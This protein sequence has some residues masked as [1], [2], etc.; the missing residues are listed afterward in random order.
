M[1]LPD[2]K[3][4]F[5]LIKSETNESGEHFDTDIKYASKDICVPLSSFDHASLTITKTKEEVN[6]DDCSLLMRIEKE[7]EPDNI[8]T[9]QTA[10]SDEPHMDDLPNNTLSFINTCITSQSSEHI[11]H[12]RTNMDVYVQQ[13][14]ETPSVVIDSEFNSPKGQCHINSDTIK[15]EVSLSPQNEVRL[16]TQ[17]CPKQNHESDNIG[18]IDVFSAAD[19]NQNTKVNPHVSPACGQRY[20]RNSHLNQYMLTDAE[21]K[22]RCNNKYAHTSSLGQHRLA[23]CV[24]CD[25]N[26]TQTFDR[27]QHLLAHARDKTYACPQCCESFEKS[28]NLLQHI[29]TQKHAY[30]DCEKRSILPSRLKK[31]HACPEC[32]KRC[33]RAGN[34]KQHMLIH[35]GKKQHACP[36]CDKRFTLA[37]Y[38][39]QHM[40]IH[41]GEKQHACPECD[42]RFTQAGNLKRHMLIHTGKKQHVCPDCDK[43]FTQAGNLKQHILTHTREK[44]H[45]CPECGKRCTRAGDLKQHMLIHTGKKQHACPDCDK[46]FTQAGNLKQH[47]KRKTTCLTRM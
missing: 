32:G 9:I 3:E 22:N 19:V 24:P 37:N 33:T 6:A 28:H 2:D 7:T 15:T 1:D 8:S 20:V 47:I 44:Q 25:K 38:L 11:V 4:S 43:R 30:P 18:H 45:V 46:R 29:L 39:R 36:E 40:L 12:H 35:T 41:T 34:L 13:Q 16:S 31:R 26:C 21:E 42:S 17:Y 23:K 14:I 5:T 10:Y 27:N